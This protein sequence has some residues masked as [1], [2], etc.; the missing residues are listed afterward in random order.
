MRIIFT[1]MALYP[2]AI[3][4]NVPFP[5]MAVLLFLLMTACGEGGKSGSSEKA[6]PYGEI[7]DS[8]IRENKEL[9][10][11]EQENIENF[12]ERRGWDMK[13]TGTGLRYLIY[14]KGKGQKARKGLMAKV[15]YEVSLL[16]GT[17]VYTSDS[18]GA[19]SFRIGQD[20]VESGLHEGILRMREGGKAKFILP[21]HLAHGLFGDLRKIPVHASIVY[22]IALLELHEPSRGEP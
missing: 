14:E 18:T 9:A 3:R 20:D 4:L 15:N 1:S 5:G 19:K 8:L 22:D 11:M 17:V 12:L 13:Q 10:R 7:K 6:A 16:D 21:A 2:D